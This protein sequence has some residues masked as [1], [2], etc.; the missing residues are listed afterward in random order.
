MSGI[1]CIY[2]AALA[3]VV[4]LRKPSKATIYCHALARLCGLQAAPQTLAKPNA[5][6]GAPGKTVAIAERSATSTD[7]LF[8]QSGIRRCYLSASSSD[9]INNGSKL[10]EKRK[11][12]A[13]CT[14]RSLHIGKSGTHFVRDVTF[15]WMLRPLLHRPLFLEFLKSA[16]IIQYTIKGRFMSR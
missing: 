3:L 5:H 10:P 14:L 16:T 4:F 13:V 1:R 7:F 9:K 12:S 11:A 8:G 15:F 2:I 6:I